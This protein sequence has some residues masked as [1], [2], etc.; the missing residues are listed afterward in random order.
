[1][2]VIQFPT[3]RDDVEPSATGL[4]DAVT[5]G[6][7]KAV[8]IVTIEQRPGEGP[9]ARL[10]HGWGEGAITVYDLLALAAALEQAKLAVH[11]ELEA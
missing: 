6:E 5:A 7:V 3:A 2:S 10:R 8:V 9:H 11:S 4:M 1:M